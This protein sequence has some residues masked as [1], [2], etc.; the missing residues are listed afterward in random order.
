MP[1]L[2]LLAALAAAGCAAIPAEPPAPPAGDEPPQRQWSAAEA[3]ALVERD[4]AARLG[5]AALEEALGA[6]TSVLMRRPIPFPRMI[7]QPD[8]SWEAEPPQV[9]AAMRTRQGWTG[10]SGGERF[11]FDPLAARELDRLIGSR[12]LWDEPELAESGCTDPAGITSVL[13]H[14]G[15]MRV[16]TQ[17]CGAAGLSGRLAA[18]VLAGRVTDWSGIPPGDRPDGVELR[19]FH[20]RTQQYL[21]LAGDLREP[22][23]LVVREPEQ[24]TG[25]WRRITVNQGE[26]PPPPE[27][28]FGREMLLIAAM[29][30]QPSG[31]YRIRIERVLDNGDALEA[32]VVRISPG[33]GCG[34]IAAL[35][36]PV[37]IVRVGASPRP[38]HWLV[39][40]EV[41][42]CH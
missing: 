1:P 21:Q 19:R 30:T 28:D 5:E 26:L 42:D 6:P 16:A 23:N 39:R 27:V 2:I 36:H 9:A 10:W 22:V 25:M 34:A 33:P 12:E 11:G 8:G 32:H 37:D 13:R 18:I 35:T 14:N 20:E 24:W 29:G 4:A 17:P 31:G 38:V 40:D 15:R 7:R 41:S 3:R